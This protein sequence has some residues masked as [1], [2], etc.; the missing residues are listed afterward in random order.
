VTPKASLYEYVRGLRKKGEHGKVFHYVTPTSE[1]LGWII[2]RATGSSWA[3]Q[4][5]KTIFQLLGP[6]RDGFVIVDAVGTQ[7][8][9]GGLALTLRDA[10][11]FGQMIANDGTLAGRRILPTEVVRRIK[12]GGDPSR[13]TPQDWAKGVHSY[14][15]QW[16]IDHTAHI[17]TA[18][19]IHG[20]LIRIGLDDGIVVVVQSSWPAAGGPDVLAR[21][22]AF[23]DAVRAGLH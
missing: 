21:Q 8:A 17:L 6:E 14:G 10:G 23:Y 4:F 16:W 9:A 12:R 19:G 20:Q 15:S 1:V 18:Y 2:A 3:D 13:W 5:E 22:L 11:R 7:T